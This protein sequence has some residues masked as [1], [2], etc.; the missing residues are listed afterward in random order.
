[1]NPVTETRTLELT[2]LFYE[3]QRR[4]FFLRYELKKAEAHTA[5]NIDY[6]RGRITDLNRVKDKVVAR[7]PELSLEPTFEPYLVSV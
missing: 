5:D 1:M 4:I 7:V 6:F 2:E 3:L